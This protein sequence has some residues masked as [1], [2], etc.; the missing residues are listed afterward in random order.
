MCRSSLVRTK[1]SFVI[2]S[3][4]N[5]PR[6]A[7]AFWSAHSWADSPCSA[8]LSLTYILTLAATLHAFRG[9]RPLLQVG[10]AYP[11][12][13]AIAKLA[14]TPGGLGAL[15]SAMIAGLTGFGLPAGEAVSAT[16]AFRLATFW[17]PI[18]PGWASMGWMQRNGEI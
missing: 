4:S 5:V 1:S 10:A 11:V 2:S 12:A 3:F 13:T 8:A 6:N 18:L 15:E 9:G 16:L 17:L 7:A 14:P